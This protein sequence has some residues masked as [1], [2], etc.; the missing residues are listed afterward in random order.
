[1]MTQPHDERRE[2]DE[3]RFSSQDSLRALLLSDALG[4]SLPT[5]HVTSVIGRENI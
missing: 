4:N 1:M 3:P 2:R 5:A